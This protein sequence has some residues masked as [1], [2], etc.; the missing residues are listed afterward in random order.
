MKLMTL[1]VNTAQNWPLLPLL[2]W[3]WPHLLMLLCLKPQNQVL[4]QRKPTASRQV[5]W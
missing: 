1:A 4:M 2:H 5:G 3:H